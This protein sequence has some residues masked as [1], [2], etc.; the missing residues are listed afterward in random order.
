[1]KILSVCKRCIKHFTERARNW[2]ICFQFLSIYFCFV[3]DHRYRH[4][5]AC[6]RCFDYNG[7]T[8]AWIRAKRVGIG[9]A[10]A[11][12]L[13]QISYL[14]YFRVATYGKV[15]ANIL[16]LQFCILLR[17]F[18]GTFRSVRKLFSLRV[19]Y[20]DSK[21]ECEIKRNKMN[22]SSNREIVVPF[23]R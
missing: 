19:L 18:N 21:H 9:I 4:R 22:A 11:H 23:T 16:F 13:P 20:L 17:T 5:H 14:K 7:K 15:D 2:V 3:H 12:T 10:R 6:W 1:M 8:F